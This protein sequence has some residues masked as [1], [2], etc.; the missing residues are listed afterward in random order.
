MFEP[1]FASEPGG[2]QG[3]GWYL[4]LLNLHHDGA[5][6]VQVVQR[7]LKRSR[8][9]RQDVGN[10]LRGDEGWRPQLV[11]CTALLMTDPGD[12]P[13]DELLQAIRNG[14]WI[15]P[16]LIATASAASASAWETEVVQAVIDRGDSEAAAALA[17][18]WPGGPA[19]LRSLA[20]TDDQGGA[21]IVRYWLNSLASAFDDAGASRTWRADQ[22]QE[23][24]QMTSSDDPA[25][26]DALGAHARRPEGF[27]VYTGPGWWPLVAD[28][29]AE[30]A[31]RFPAYTLAAVKEKYGRLAFQA[32][33]RPRSEPGA[34]WSPEEH[35][36]LD[37]ITERFGE[38]SETICEW[39]GDPGEL[40]FRRRW[41]LTLCDRCDARF[42]DPP[43]RLHGK[44]PKRQGS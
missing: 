11:G 10:L 44:L 34:S 12:R 15:A 32:F 7:C 25:L 19:D 35:E 23:P 3:P 8:D 14:S 17:E 36:A 41:E 5:A 30:I 2:K 9:P 27:T 33:P 4:V 16:Q 21:S 43:Y 28:C 31:T 37:R 18:L 26:L 39:C 6:A 22:D 38:L 13:V 42:P 1:L 24:W 20:A 40:R 29:H